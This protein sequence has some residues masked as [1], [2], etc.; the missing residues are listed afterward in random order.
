MQT[1]IK[2]LNFLNLY[3]KKEYFALIFFGNFTKIILRNWKSINRLKWNIKCEQLN[4]QYFLN[5]KFFLSN[6]YSIFLLSARK[7]LIKAFIKTIASNSERTDTIPYTCNSYLRTCF[8]FPRSITPS[9]GSYVF[10]LELWE[11]QRAWFSGEFCHDK[12]YQE[13]AYRFNLIQS[14]NFGLGENQKSENKIWYYIQLYTYTC[15]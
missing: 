9:P 12:N 14:I 6:V 5:N 1:S 8:L 4:F 3:R 10:A 2:F 15:T 7:A 11:L 13:I